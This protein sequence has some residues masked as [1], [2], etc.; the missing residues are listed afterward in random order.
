MG[1]V[2]EYEL[3]I[4]EHH[5]DTFGHV[6][7]AAYLQLLEEAR[8]DLIT[9]GGYGLSEIARLRQGPTMLEC[10]LRYRREV[11]NR[12]RVLIRTWLESYVGKV[13]VVQQQ[14]QVL[15]GVAGAEPNCVATMSLGLLDMDARRLI[16]PTEAWLRCWGLSRTDWQPKA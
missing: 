11:L 14:L 12:Q 15:E 16:E 9:Q 5:L 4:R 8:W 6:N 10:T 13:A 1:P 7:N 3:T 2:H